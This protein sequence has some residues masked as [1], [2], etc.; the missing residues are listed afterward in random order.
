MATTQQIDN[1]AEEITSNR[2]PEMGSLLRITVVRMENFTNWVW[3]AAANWKQFICAT[4]FGEV[5]ISSA[6]GGGY[7]TPEYD[8]IKCEFPL[9][10]G[11]TFDAIIGECTYGLARIV[12]TGCDQNVFQQHRMK[13]ASIRIILLSMSFYAKRFPVDGPKIIVVNPLG[14]RQPERKLKTFTDL[15][16][17]SQVAGF[18][19]YI[20]LTN[21]RGRPTCESGA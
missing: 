17:R 6:K 18:C 13:A 19:L 1:H 14:R 3:F 16:P 2:I 20:S 9:E 10:V 15:V 7:G 21:E 11:K 8:T 5:T 12:Q 4:E